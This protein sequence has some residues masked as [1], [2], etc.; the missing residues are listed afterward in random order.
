MLLEVRSL[1]QSFD[2]VYCRFGSDTLPNSYKEVKGKFIGIPCIAYELEVITK[3]KTESVILSTIIELIN[4]LENKKG[5]EHGQALDKVAQMTKL[6]RILI[7]TVWDEHKDTLN[8]K[9][10][11][12]DDSPEKY[13]VRVFLNLVT[14]EFFQVCIDEED[15]QE[16]TSFKFINP[17]NVDDD[18]RMEGNYCYFKKDIGRSFTYCAAVLDCE[19]PEGI[20]NPDIAT[21]DKVILS[22]S[23]FRH[24][25]SVN[26]VK[27][28]NWQ[29]ILL[30]A[31]SYLSNVDL[32]TYHIADPFFRKDREEIRNTISKCN[33]SPEIKFI[34]NYFNNKIKLIL[35]DS[36]MSF[37][38]END[39]YSL[40]YITLF[41]YPK[42]RASVE[43][44][45]K[46]YRLVRSNKQSS[47]NLH[48]SK[49]N[50]LQSL[51]NNA[52]AD[53]I[54][55]SVEVF[56]N[57]LE[58]VFQQYL[59]VAVGLIERETSTKTKK[60]DKE[61]SRKRG[62]NNFYR[63]VEL[64][65]EVGFI[66]TDNDAKA[67]LRVSE[68][69]P[70]NTA[71]LHNINYNNSSVIKWF[72]LNLLEAKVDKA[73]PWR[74]VAEKYSDLGSY[75]CKM[76]KVRDQA[77]HDADEKDK[78]KYN[79]LDYIYNMTHD[80]I[81]ITLVPEYEF[82]TSANKTDD[83]S[84]TTIERKA[85]DE[86]RKYDELYNSNILKRKAALVC[87]YYI[88]KDSQYIVVCENLIQALLLAFVEEHC[89][90]FDNI[91]SVFTK[92]RQ[93]DYETMVL[94]YIK[95]GYP[96][97]ELI[98]K[99][100][101]GKYKSWIDFPEKM[102]SNQLLYM[103]FAQLDKS[104]PAFLKILIETYPDII[105]DIDFISVLRKHNEHTDFE[106][107]KK[108]YPDFHDKFLKS[109]NRACKLLK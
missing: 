92:N 104:E 17:L 43:D 4:V 58:I 77:K 34:E 45:D 55:A 29:E 62:I 8:N 50:E 41:K 40:S 109:I 15:Y 59:S 13:N 88:V 98:S 108:N 66:Y 87:Q 76:D 74:R 25:D 103:I 49:Q 70:K 14:K 42:L 95:Y 33:T 68:S 91:E 73:N 47:E 82:G 80:I 63:V 90:T 106:K 12:E 85:L 56:E 20:V 97:D 94:L 72:I 31:L 48:E 1:R 36:Q 64:I 21:L 16:K 69:I 39:E 7:K 37:Q 75:L 3:G 79:E 26:S 83:N 6:D 86:L 52:R 101:T 61:K 46:R 9:T 19:K 53:F 57:L 78:F 2:T 38:D 32:I 93:E 102:T 5:I 28:K 84:E 51:D 27:I 71:E 105:K 81:K 107:I 23:K 89:K 10:G 67:Y 11:A 24:K 35:D 30:V 18:I 65:K 54:R 44:L 100:N 99:P 60:I 96:G 22:D